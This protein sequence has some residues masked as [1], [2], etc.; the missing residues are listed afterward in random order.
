MTGVFGILHKRPLFFPFENKD[1]N[2]QFLPCSS[3]WS[4]RTAF[5]DHA[6]MGDT[7]RRGL[8]FKIDNLENEVGF[9]KTKR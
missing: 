1:Y 8:E 9:Y 5:A 7:Y 6:I 4:Q 3:T 2:I